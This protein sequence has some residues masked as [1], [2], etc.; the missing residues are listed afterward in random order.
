MST[1]N[2]TAVPG[3]NLQDDE[4]P[5]GKLA[6]G[7]STRIAVGT[8]IA[9]RALVSITG[10]RLQIPDGERFVHLQFRRFAGCPV[11]NFHL[12]SF[13]RRHGEIAAAGIREVVVFHSAAE[14]LA[15]H[16]HQLPF[17]VV[18]DPDKCLY[19]E[20]GVESGLRAMLDPRAWLPILRAVFY[21]LVA[22]ARGKGRPPAA[23]P[24]GGR[25]GLPADFLIACDGRVVAAKYGEHVDD[26]WS[27][28]ELLEARVGR[29]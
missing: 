12:R 28:D 23:F 13:V 10:E 27:V 1:R 21:S 26:H 29:L 2:S 22:I 8:L 5:A 25:Y 24:Q 7:S 9:P 19:R 20:F 6:V 11:C 15:P 4:M 14:E 3:P 16:T 18:G 17:A